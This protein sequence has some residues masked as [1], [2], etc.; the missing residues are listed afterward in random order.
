MFATAST[1]YSL[2]AWRR[3]QTHH[4]NEISNTENRSDALNSRDPRCWF[5]SVYNNSY[6][7]NEN[8][9]ATTEWNTCSAPRKWCEG[10]RS[11]ESRLKTE[12]SR[13]LFNTSRMCVQLLG[14]NNNGNCSQV[15]KLCLLFCDCQ[16]YKQP[17]CGNLS[18]G[19]VLLQPE[20]EQSQMIWQTLTTLPTNNSSMRVLKFSSCLWRGGPNK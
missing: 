19:F 14:G 2:W 7:S 10:R 15:K 9:A 16:K 18:V 12:E 5:D 11:M 13:K 1:W 3:Q 17:P 20:W 6:S 8:A 4:T